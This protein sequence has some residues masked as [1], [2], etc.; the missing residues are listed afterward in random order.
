MLNQVEVD[1]AREQVRKVL[2]AADNANHAGEVA[3][4]RAAKALDEKRLGPVSADTVLLE[5]IGHLGAAISQSIPS[6][7][8]IIVGHIREAHNLAKMLRGAQ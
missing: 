1:R 3:V 7:D 2:N 5:I 8:Q 4:L 6:D